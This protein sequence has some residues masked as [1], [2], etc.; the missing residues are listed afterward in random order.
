MIPDEYTIVDLWNLYDLP[1]SKRNHSRLVARVALYFAQRVSNAISVSI[2][3][4]LLYAGAM[5]HDLDKN[6]KKEK[7]EHHPDTGV[8]VLGEKGFGEVADLIKMHSLPSILNQT[9]ALKTWEE[10]LLFLSDKMVKHEV[11][12]VDERFR[13]WRKESL[14]QDTVIMLDATYPLVK[15]LEKEVFTIIGITAKDVASLA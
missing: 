9:M 1:E 6:I 4:A 3:T 13:L 2:D 8:R 15:A 12:T 7:G 11:I 10:K 14:P 5:L